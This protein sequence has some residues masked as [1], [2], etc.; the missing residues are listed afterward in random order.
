MA[1][2]KS[3]STKILAYSFLGFTALTTQ[4]AETFKGSGVA[5]IINSDKATARKT[6]LKSAIFDASTKQ[7]SNLFGYTSTQSGRITDDATVLYTNAKLVNYSI[8][9][10]KTE[11]NLVKIA[12][13]ATFSKNYKKLLCNKKKTQSITNI[14]YPTVKYRNVSG[15]EKFLLDDYLARSFTRFKRDTRE[16]QKSPKNQIHF[17]NASQMANRTP[18]SYES[19]L[20]G[21]QE[22]KDKNI[23]EIFFEFEFDRVDKTFY[24]VYRLN[25]SVKLNGKQFD[26][27]NIPSGSIEFGL[28][29]DVPS[30][31]L[32]VLSSSGLQL[33]QV[34]V[35]FEQ[36]LNLKKII[37][38]KNPGCRIL[39]AKLEFSPRG[40]YIKLGSQNGISKND[41]GWFTPDGV[42]DQILIIER[43]EANRTFFKTIEAN[44]IKK[45]NLPLITMVRYE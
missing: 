37:I 5:R 41:L 21:S 42:T 18:G 9:E 35:P 3:F 38:P 29:I 33:S 7:R 20:Y 22:I 13:S 28:E 2:F 10:E 39:M 34:D 30:R 15:E 43:V 11:N 1:F 26:G 16:T 27:I 36:I 23:N 40:H 24:S 4:A 32:N 19:Y 17:K 25:Y 6:A 45:S 14:Y 44:T 31:A 12:V 8:L